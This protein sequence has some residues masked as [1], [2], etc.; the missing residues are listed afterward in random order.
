LEID[1]DSRKLSLGHKQ[2][3]EN[4]WDTFEQVFPV[5]SYQE[6]TILRKDDRGAIVQLPY[7]LEAFAPIKHIRKEDGSMANVEE[8]LTVKVIEFNRDDKRILVSHLRY[9]DDIRRDAGEAVKKDKDEQR[10]QTRNQVKKTQS[11]ME[12]TTLGEMDVFSQLRGQIEADNK[13]AKEEAK[14]AKVEVKKEAPVKAKA[15]PVVSEEVEIEE[16]IEIEEVT[17][18]VVA[19]DLKKIEGIG[20]KISELLQN[21]G[22]KTFAQLADAKV[23]KLK[24][25][26][27]A[28][29]SRYKMHDP[30]TWPQQSALAATGKWDELKVLQDELQGG[31]KA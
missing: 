17:A 29:G 18:D 1:K 15:E 19:D 26:L 10:T 6:A 9:L 11:K 7:G 28:A 5:G 21:G 27:E 3:E 8:I 20:P 23:E 14:P 2:I 24:E 12:R 31:K 13:S 4:P 22:I 16:E 25:I 30:T